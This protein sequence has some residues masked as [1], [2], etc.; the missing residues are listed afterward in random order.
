MKAN[1]FSTLFNEACDH[2]DP[3]VLREPT[4]SVAQ[5]PHLNIRLD[6]E[7]WPKGEVV[8]VTHLGRE[9]IANST[10]ANSS[11]KGNRS[12][13]IGQLM[14]AG[15]HG[16]PAWCAILGAV[17]NQNDH[18]KKKSDPGRPALNSLPSRQGLQH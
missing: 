10:E 4:G 6:R 7:G 15:G 14:V 16:R 8:H 9:A 11:W 17:H 5:H 3:A 12:A 1:Q 2:T 18:E 13:S